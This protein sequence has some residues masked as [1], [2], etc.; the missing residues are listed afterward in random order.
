MRQRLCFIGLVLA[1]HQVQRLLHSLIVLEAAWP[2]NEHLESKES[3][4]GWGFAGRVFARV[5]AA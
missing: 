4:A 5:N 3:E 2:A 1:Q